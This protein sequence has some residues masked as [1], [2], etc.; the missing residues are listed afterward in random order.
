MN[1]G[2][3]ITWNPMDP[4]NWENEGEIDGIFEV[5]ELDILEELD[6][7]KDYKFDEPNF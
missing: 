6:Y 3:Q 1:A 2:H 5:Y 7:P 4:G